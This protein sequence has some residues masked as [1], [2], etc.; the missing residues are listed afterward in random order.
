MEKYYL[1]VLIKGQFCSVLECR[2]WEIVVR[3]KLVRKFKSVL[4]EREG[5]ICNIGIVEKVV[6]CYFI[7]VIWRIELDIGCEQNIIF[8]VWFGRLN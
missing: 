4:V 2:L 1:F 7:Y 3:Q 5:E 8:D 6:G